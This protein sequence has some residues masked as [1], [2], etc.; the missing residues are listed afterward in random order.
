MMLR[1]RPL[2][3]AYFNALVERDRLTGK[4]GEAAVSESLSALVNFA[5]SKLLGGRNQFSSSDSDLMY[6]FAAS[7]GCCLLNL[8]VDPGSELSATL[9][10]S[11]M[12][13]L[14]VC[15]MHCC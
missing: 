5:K 9:V 12:V 2:W 1:G 7:V 13:R 3:R 10:H 11:H 15:C 4:L 6:P 14:C 8:V